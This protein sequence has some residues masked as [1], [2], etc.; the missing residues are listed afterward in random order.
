MTQKNVAYPKIHLSLDNCFAIKRWVR[1]R[2]WMSIVKQIGGITN[3]QASTDNEIDPLFNT[4]EYR[5]EWVK[6]VKKYEKL[7][8]LKVVS[9]Y[10]GYAT[11]RTTGLAH[12]DDT[13]RNVLVNNYYKPVVDI[14]EKLG[15]QVGNTLGAFSEPILNDPAEYRKAD[16][17]LME[18][19]TVMT[20]Y[21]QEKGVIFSYEQMYT[22]NQG[23]WTIDGCKNYIKT[24]YRACN[25]PMYITIDTAHQVGQR[26]FIS[27]ND[28]Q[29]QDMIST[30]DLG[31]FRLGKRIEKMIL[32]GG[33]SVADIRRAISIHIIN[34]VIVVSTKQRFLGSLILPSKV[35]F[36]SG[37]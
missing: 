30:R 28:R 31:E 25:Y 32:E 35:S 33:H 3:I 11:Y 14:A 13:C 37:L 29:I 1:P 18:K 5:D 10:S 26:F 4:P 8:G 24:I 17:I 19:L 6:E 20:K 27:P 15:A 12:W 34:A 23:F 21:A 36:I 7:L 9:L 2:D 16:D 22:P